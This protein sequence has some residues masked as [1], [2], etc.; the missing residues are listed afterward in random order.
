MSSDDER[1]FWLQ[2]RR[3]LC[4]MLDA[5]DRAGGRRDPFWR[6]VHGGLADVVRAIETHW[7]F[8][9]H[10][11]TTLSGNTGEPPLA[12]LAQSQT[13]RIER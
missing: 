7:R 11:R 9:R 1:V 13:E 6:D 2:M 4:T 12:A 8:P 5:I 10:S 3:G